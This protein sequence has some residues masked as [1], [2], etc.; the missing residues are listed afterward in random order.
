MEKGD[1]LLLYCMEMEAFD[2]AEAHDDET[3]DSEESEG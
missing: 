1:D 3:S 2:I